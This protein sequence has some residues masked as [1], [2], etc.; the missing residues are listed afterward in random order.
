MIFK[1]LTCGFEGG[2]A[3]LYVSLPNNKKQSDSLLLL[4]LRNK[5]TAILETHQI[6]F[7]RGIDL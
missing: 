6:I 1:I 5:K 3:Q 4:I 7:K 2:A